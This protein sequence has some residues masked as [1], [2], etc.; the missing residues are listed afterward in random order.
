MF[1]P[2]ATGPAGTVRSARSCTSLSTVVVML[3][4]ASDSGPARATPEGTAVLTSAAGPFDATLSHGSAAEVRTSVPSGVTLTGPESEAI[5]SIT[6]T[7]D[8]DVE[9]GVA[10]KEGRRR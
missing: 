8:N 2:S 6:T 5:G 9:R 3:P 10:R 4:I 1:E 7:V